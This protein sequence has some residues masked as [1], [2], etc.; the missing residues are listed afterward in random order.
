[1]RYISSPG[2]ITLFTLTC[3]LLSGVPLASATPVGT[4][5][6][7]GARPISVRMAESIVARGEGMG[8]KAGKP[9]IN[10]E[11]GTFQSA[12]WNLYTETKNETYLS[13]IAQGLDRVIT[14]DGGVIDDFDLEAYALDDVRVGASMV[15][16]WSVNKMDKYKSAAGVLAAQFKTQPRTKEGAFWHKQIYTDQQWLDGIYM[17]YITYALYASTFEPATTDK[18]FTDIGKQF[19]LAWEHCHDAK[20]GLLRHGWDSSKKMKWADPTTG[21]S[22]EVWSR[23]LGWHVMALADFLTPPLVIPSS[24]ATYKILLTQVK[25]IIPALVANADPKTG[26]WWLV[27]SQPGK[28]GN[29]IETSGTAMFIYGMLKSVR[30]GVVDDKDG[31][32]VASAV[33]AYEYLVRTQLVQGAQLDL[34]GTVSVGSLKG[35]GDYA[36]Y[37]GVETALNDLKGTAPFVMASLEYEKLKK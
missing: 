26:A 28:K 14:A 4:A 16:L 31:K 35:D 32:I 19:S 18:V 24:H 2:G 21:A 36:Y 5:A 11:H 20:N 8:L 37:I 7:A 13:W 25:A 10:Y 29:Y 9:K 6:A 30:L 22:P 3:S 12:L 27:M 23:G 15:N 1:M 33:K 34:K 17:G